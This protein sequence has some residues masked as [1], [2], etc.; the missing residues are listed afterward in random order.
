MAQDVMLKIVDRCLSLEETA[1]QVYRELASSSDHAEIRRFWSAMSQEEATHIRFW[2]KLREVAQESSLPQVF[3][4][5]EIV[6]QDL[7][8]TDVKVK[9]L[10]AKC[11]ALP[12][13][14][15]PFI[16][17]CRLEFHLLHPSFSFF[18]H[19]ARTLVGDETI[20]GNYDAHLDRLAELVAQY[21][22]ATP[23]MEMIGEALLRLWKG[24]KALA[25]QAFADRLTGLLNRRGFLR[26]A[27]HLIHLARR[28][29]E[30][31]GLLMIDVD[32]FKKV[33]DRLGHEKG[34]QAL[35]HLAQT[36]RSNIRASDLVCRHGG[37]EFLVF[38]FGTGLRGGQI[39][40]EKIRNAV[41][42]LLFRYPLTVSIGVA[43][44]EAS[45]DARLEI[46]DLIRR[47]DAALG[48]AK[49]MGGNRVAVEESGL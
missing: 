32:H 9:A 5:P 29:T 1:M 34:D 40:A 3:D 42:R 28:R 15:D 21:A 2:R 49:Q 7:V 47:A 39:V 25:E 27:E 13:I 30:P 6:L 16:V 36:L 48:R 46:Q 22:P 4:E 10:L 43:A 41:E 14:Q 18:L 44:R 19:N 33:N 37:E 31:V 26:I 17:A 11:R 23:E 24:N 35:A 20:E 8:D 38:L 12:G 45:P